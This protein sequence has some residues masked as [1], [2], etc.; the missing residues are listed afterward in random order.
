MASIPSSPSKR[1][2][3]PWSCAR[4]PSEPPEHCPWQRPLPSIVA[5][6]GEQQRRQKRN[7]SKAEWSGPCSPLPPASLLLPVAALSKTLVALHNGK[8]DKAWQSSAHSRGESPP[9][10]QN[11]SCFEGHT[12]ETVPSSSGRSLPKRVERMS[13]C[14]NGLGEEAGCQ[15]SET[16]W[17]QQGWAVV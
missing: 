14:L 5:L 15:G 6:P 1:L 13:H 11:R 8:G 12:P 10:E 4:W 2:K 7:D 16:S 3:A 9:L 17:I